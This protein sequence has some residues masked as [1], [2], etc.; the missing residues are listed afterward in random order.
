MQDANKIISDK[1]LSVMKSRNITRAKLANAA[2][3]DKLK[4]D[5]YLQLKAK[6][7]VE[8]VRRIFYILDISFDNLFDLKQ[9]INYPLKNWNEYSE[10][11]KVADKK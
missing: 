10:L 8:C 4:L 11:L 3:I 9:P 5:N 6:W 2:D 1:I 7:N